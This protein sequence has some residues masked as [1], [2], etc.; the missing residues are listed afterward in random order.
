MQIEVPQID[1]TLWRRLNIEA[2]HR[3]KSTTELLQEAL[4]QY[5]DIRPIRTEPNDSS[6]LRR[7][8]GTW[9]KEEAEEFERNIEWTTRIDEDMWK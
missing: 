3:G 5:L 6:N 1:P 4:Y 7:L 8:A 2:K 9:S